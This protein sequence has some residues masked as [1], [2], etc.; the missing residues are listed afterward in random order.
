[1]ALALCTLLAAANFLAA[2]IGL[3]KKRDSPPYQAF[4]EHV[5]MH[6]LQGG[7]AVAGGDNDGY[8]AIA[9]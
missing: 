4:E 8:V 2:I 1:V 5:Q 3:A 6:D 9:L 7:G